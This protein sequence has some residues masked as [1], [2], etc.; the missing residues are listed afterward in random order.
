MTAMVQY[1]DALLREIE[2]FIYREARLQD[3]HE[4][5]DGEALWT[6]DGIY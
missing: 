1:D 5:D 3:E 2:Q 6:D 4:Y